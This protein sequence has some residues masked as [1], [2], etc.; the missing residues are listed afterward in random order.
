[1]KSNKIGIVAFAFGTPWNILSNIKIADIAM[2]ESGWSCGEQKFPIYTQ[3]DL[4]FENSVDATYILQKGDDPPPTLRIAQAAVRWAIHNTIS[5]LRIVCAEPHLWRCRRDLKRV[6]KESGYTIIKI[7]WSKEIEKI[8]GDV[9]FCPDSTQE[10]TRS[11]KAWNK[12]ERI[13]KIMPFWLYK[14]VES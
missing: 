11:R 13:L 2:N 5:E 6:V 1:V 12:R 8:P 10:R 9:W 14:M 3:A 7:S 4:V